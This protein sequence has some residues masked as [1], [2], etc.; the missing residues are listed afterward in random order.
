MRR[1]YQNAL[2]N[3]DGVTDGQA[4]VWTWHLC[5]STV[6][7]RYTALA[8]GWDIPKFMDFHD[9]LK[10]LSADIEQLRSQTQAGTTDEYG[11]RRWSSTTTQGKRLACSRGLTRTQYGGTTPPSTFPAGR[12]TGSR[13]YFDRRPSPVAPPGL[14]LVLRDLGGGGGPGEREGMW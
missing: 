3:E 4:G 7:S 12:S 11:V 10:L 1:T 9:G 2:G 5:A 8:R 14:D 6:A 13:P